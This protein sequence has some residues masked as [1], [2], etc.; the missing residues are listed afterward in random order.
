METIIK[1]A[2]ITL[3]FTFLLLTVIHFTKLTKRKKPKLILILEFNKIKIE[4]EIK[5]FSLKPKQRLKVTLKPIDK[6]GDPALIEDG[7]QN[8][9]TSDPEVIRIELIEAEPNSC[10]LYSEKLGV[11]VFDYSADADLGEGVKTISGTSNGEVMPR[12]AVG[13]GLEFG[14][15][16]DL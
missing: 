8:Y 16:E 13:F 14:E 1:L 9:Q 10:Y 12:E 3:I 15:P 2:I 7:S 6:N 4:G 11:A 5:M